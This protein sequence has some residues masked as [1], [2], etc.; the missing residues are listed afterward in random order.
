MHDCR[1]T[2]NTRLELANRERAQAYRVKNASIKGNEAEK[3]KLQ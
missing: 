1:L 2:S 3:S